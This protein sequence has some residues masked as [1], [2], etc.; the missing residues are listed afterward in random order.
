MDIHYCSIYNLFY[1]LLSGQSFR[2]RVLVILL[3]FLKVFSGFA[4]F[5][6]KVQ[7]GIQSCLSSLSTLIFSPTVL[8]WITDSRPT[9]LWS[10][11]HIPFHFNP[12]HLRKFD[13]SS[14]CFN[15]LCF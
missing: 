1:R 2:I 10:L 5:T 3:P 12:P 9:S 15:F 7:S 13:N 6:K 14:A 11:V 4:F 8:V